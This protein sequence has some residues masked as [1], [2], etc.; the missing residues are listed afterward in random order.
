MESEVSKPE[1]VDYNLK[2][3]GSLTGIIMSYNGERF[4][5]YKQEGDPATL[6][7]TIDDV[8]FVFKHNIEEGTLEGCHFGNQT[9][10]KYEIK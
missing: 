9:R 7:P 5:L 6:I 2:P 1:L 4:G 8:P 10:Y 3:D